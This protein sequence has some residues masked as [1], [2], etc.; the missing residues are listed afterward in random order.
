M[1]DFM[2]KKVGHEWELR[3]PTGQLIQRHLV[4]FQSRADA[5]ACAER[6]RNVPGADWQLPGFMENQ[7]SDVFYAAW[8][9]IYS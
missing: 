9:A 2:I 1:P 8:A 5:T 7:P 4:N 6:L 3:A